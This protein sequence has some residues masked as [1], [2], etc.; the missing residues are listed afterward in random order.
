[1][2]PKYSPRR[3][4]VYKISGEHINRLEIFDRDGW[5]CG[6][7]RTIIDKTIRLPSPM[8]ATLDHVVPLALGGLHTKDNVQAAH[9][10]CNQAKGC[11]FDWT[12]IAF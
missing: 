11:D 6:I 9:H 8:A 12:A 7:C 5:V 3:R 1:M 4:R 2:A 10:Y